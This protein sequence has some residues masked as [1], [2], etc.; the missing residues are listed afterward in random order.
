MET[1]IQ[2]Q[3]V[4]ELGCDLYQGYLMSRPTQADQ[5]DFYGKPQEEKPAVDGD[6][7]L[8]L[9]RRQSSPAA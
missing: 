6:A 3:R 9:R 2:L 5:V 4:T 7:P 8:A 1:P